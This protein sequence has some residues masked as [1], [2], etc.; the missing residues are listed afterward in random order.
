MRLRLICLHIL[1][2]PRWVGW[3][4]ETRVLFII[5]SIMTRMDKIITTHV[6][7]FVNHGRLPLH[8]LLSHIISIVTTYDATWLAYS[9]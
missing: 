7:F 4:I 5:I 9:T 2:G 3:S 6:H 8:N 1:K